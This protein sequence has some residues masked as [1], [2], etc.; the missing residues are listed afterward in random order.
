MYDDPWAASI[1]TTDSST[2][3]DLL[4]QLETGCRLVPELYR[5]ER[6]Q[7]RRNR[8]TI[9]N[10]HRDPTVRSIGLSRAQSE[11]DSIAT[12][13]TDVEENEEEGNLPNVST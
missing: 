3:A 11:T 1:L 6:I 2:N 12:A 13:C 7:R 5:M 10:L 8:E 9:V 4:R